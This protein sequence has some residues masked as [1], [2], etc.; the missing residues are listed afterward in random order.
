MLY[1]YIY[2]YIIHIGNRAAGNPWP[3][4][5]CFSPWV[6]LK[7]GVLLRRFCE[8]LDDPAGWPKDAIPPTPTSGHDA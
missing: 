4:F 5:F 1:I 3:V 2:V 8:V 7:P 6:S